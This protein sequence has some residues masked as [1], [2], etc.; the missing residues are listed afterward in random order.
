MAGGQWFR[1][2]RDKEAV[3]QYLVARDSVG[4]MQSYCGDKRRAALLR[5]TFEVG[6]QPRQPHVTALPGGDA[7]VFSHH[8]ATQRVNASCRR[9]C[10]VILLPPGLG[11]SEVCVRSMASHLVPLHMYMY[12]CMYPCVHAEGAPGRAF[13]MT[14][15][16]SI[17]L[18]VIITCHR[19]PPLP[20]LLSNVTLK[21]PCL[22]PLLYGPFTLQT[23]FF[24]V[25][26]NRLKQYNWISLDLLQ[27]Q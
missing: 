22:I 26:E 25:V 7:H 12:S 8:P 9:V 2:R 10:S 23:P 20:V 13:P 24:R 21:A 19:R 3:A 1:A 17:S 14:L 11:I 16:I 27:L 18:A 4:G 5:R 6:L 15:P